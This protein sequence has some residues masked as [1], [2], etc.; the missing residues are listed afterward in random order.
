V[1]IDAPKSADGKLMLAIEDNGG[2]MNPARLRHCMSFGSPARQQGNSF[3]TSTMRLGADTLVFTRYKKRG[4][5]PPGCC[6]LRPWQL[7]N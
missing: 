4:L 7:L 3:K 5:C 2:G 1:S 6:L